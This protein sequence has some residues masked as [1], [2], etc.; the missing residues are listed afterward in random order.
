[1]TFDDRINVFEFH[2]ISQQIEDSFTKINELTFGT[3]I[4]QWVHYFL[5][6]LKNIFNFII[7]LKFYNL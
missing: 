3:E 5:L 4:D 6:L 7:I 1:M 2:Q